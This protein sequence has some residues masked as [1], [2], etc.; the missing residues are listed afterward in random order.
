MGQ[1]S[2]D[3]VFNYKS[4]LGFN[5]DLDF[6]QPDDFDKLLID[7]SP[8]FFIDQAGLE[9]RDPPASAY[10]GVHHLCPAAVDL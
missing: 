2:W 1:G 5:F 7:W 3:G 4:Y 6:Y 8:N 9:L 10:R